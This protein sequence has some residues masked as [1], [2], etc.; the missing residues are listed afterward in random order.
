[1]ATTPHLALTLVEQ[2][3]AQKEVTVNQALTRIDALLNTSALSKSLS[4]PPVSPAAG[5]V[6]IVAASPTGDWAGQ[7]G[8]IAYY[9]QVWR[10]ITPQEGMCLWVASEDTFYVYNGSSWA[11]YSQNTPMLGVNATADSTN[12]LAVAS[13]AVLFNHNGTSTQVKLN[14]NASGNT[15]SFLY[16]TNFSGRA[17]FGTIGDDHFTLK[18]SPDGS[19]WLDALKVSSSTGRVARKS[20]AVGLSAAGSNQAGATAL[21]KSVNIVSSVSSGQGVRL[22][23]PDAGEFILVANQGAN[24]L[25]VYPDTGHTINAL[26]ANTALS[27]VAD[28]RRLFFAASGTAWYSL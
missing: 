27:I 17:E 12:K 25:S 4:A 10:F 9:D 1:M 2:A 6:Y 24:N 11:L 5:N 18:V 7:V 15:A 28:A 26:S 13:D 16:Q 23:T 22:P 20:L 3:Q 21:S 8:K 14:K 19:S